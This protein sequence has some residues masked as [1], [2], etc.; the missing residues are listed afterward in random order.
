MFSIGQFSLLTGLTVKALRFYDETGLL[1]PHH[2][3]PASGY[4]RYSAQ[5]ARRA[6]TVL[7]LRQAGLPLGLV[8][9]VVDAPERTQAVVDRHEQ[10]RLVERVRQDAALARAR[11]V[12]ASYDVPLEVRTRSAPQQHWAGIE[13]RLD[14]DDDLQSAG[15][16]TDAALAELAGALQAAGHPP[17]GPFWTTVTS[18]GG[19]RATLTLCWPVE[20]SLTG[21]ELAS[22]R[23]VVRGTL[24]ARQE[25]YVR[26]DADDGLE[27]QFDPDVEDGVE[28][29]D[30][31]TVA[32]HP[33]LLA[34]LEHLDAAA[35]D[36]SELRQVAVLDE[37]GLPVAVEA[38]VTV[39]EV[40][41]AP[42]RR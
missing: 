4:R 9:Q 13:Q 21:S 12:L 19:A 3:D 27:P 38:C 39:P 37:D 31:G 28:A 6:S 34:L 22:E 23:P 20:R 25:A 5:Q 8:Q 17:V 24:P 41:A 32:A 40:G 30:A 7:V 14:L 11:A 16:D 18:D 26:V 2:V 33:A 15:P 36:L 1:V 29:P 10:E 35:A 42:V